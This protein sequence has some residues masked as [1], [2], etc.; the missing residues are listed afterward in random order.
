MYKELLKLNTHKTDNHVKKWAE[1]MNRHFSNEDIQMGIRHMKKCSSSLAIREIQ[2]KTTL[3]YQL[4]LVRM[5]KINKTGNN[6]FW[7]GLEKGEPSYTVGGNAS[8][9]SDIGRCGDSLRN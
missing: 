2:I 5:A 7:R 6:V 4:T 1:D 3:R 8:W 9:C